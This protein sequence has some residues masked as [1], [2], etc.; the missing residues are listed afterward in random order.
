MNTDVNYSHES[1]RLKMRD[2]LNIAHVHALE[3]PP[4]R[5]LSMCN[6]SDLE[7]THIHTLVVTERN[8]IPLPLEETFL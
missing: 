3:S 5:S 8:F 2:G 1:A 6:N 4:L 7:F